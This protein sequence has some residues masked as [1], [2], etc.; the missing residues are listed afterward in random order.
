MTTYQQKLHQAHKERLSRMG[1]APK[2]KNDLDVALEAGRIA[3][4]PRL[5][6][7]RRVYR[8]RVLPIMPALETTVFIRAP[9]SMP[10]KKHIIEN[11]PA[12]TINAAMSAVCEKY[13]LLPDEV[14]SWSGSRYSRVARYEFCWLAWH[15]TELNSNA[16]RDLI[17]CRER[18]YLER[19]IATHQK[20]IHMG[21]LK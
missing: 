9:G 13:G 20:R 19:A 18:I 12:I 5:E 16:L 3:R 2:I 15:E 14:T 6:R 7:A 11:R 8:M 17:G 1:A 21:L 10:K 4:L